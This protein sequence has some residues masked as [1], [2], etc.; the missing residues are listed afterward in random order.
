MTIQRDITDQLPESCVALLLE[1]LS[2]SIC[3]AVN[4]AVGKVKKAPFVTSQ[5]S[6][7]VYCVHT[8]IENTSCQ[9]P[10]ASKSKSFCHTFS[11]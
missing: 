11:F 7:E 3:C 4:V 5:K 8:A 2:V 9:I 1:S 6:D 10:D